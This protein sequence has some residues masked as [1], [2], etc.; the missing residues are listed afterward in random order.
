MRCN[1]VDVFVLGA[2]RRF[3]L[4]LRGQ[5][6]QFSAS[7]QRFN[8]R[9][10]ITNITTALGAM[11]ARI[12]TNPQPQPKYEEIIIPRRINLP[13]GFESTCIN[14]RFYNISYWS[15]SRGEASEW[16]QRPPS[17]KLCA[18]RVACCQRLHNGGEEVTVI[19][20]WRR[21]LEV[22]IGGHMWRRESGRGGW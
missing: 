10:I 7:I 5:T 13:L 22:G 9:N 14:S 3:R 15:V 11:R 19:G 4:K 20:P 17:I 2:N 12:P 16:G 18:G 1:S 8:R 21:F 6:R